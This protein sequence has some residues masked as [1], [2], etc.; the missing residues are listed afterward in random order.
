MSTEQAVLNAQWNAANET[1]ITEQA[2]RA[3]HVLMR[4]AVFP[5]GNAWCALYGENIQEG[6]AGFG[7]TPQAAAA[8]FDAN[9]TRQKLTHGVQEVPRG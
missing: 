3:P 1:Q 7:D 8:D 9:W 2:R 6:V 5:D 4:P